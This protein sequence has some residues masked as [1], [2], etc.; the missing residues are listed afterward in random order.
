M[1]PCSAARM[2]RGFIWG[3]ILCF[4]LA[5]RVT[6][7]VDVDLQAKSWVFAKCGENVNLTCNATSS[8][9]WDKDMK[10]KKFI[11]MFGNKTMCH[12]EQNHTESEFQCE[13]IQDTFSHTITLTLNNVMP[14]DEGKYLCKFHST[15]G[16]KD[17]VSQLRIQDCLEN[18]G[19]SRN[20][21]YAECFFEGVYPS[22]VVHWYQGDTNL[23]TDV[24]TQET[25]D[26]RNHFNIRSS[27]KLK[28]E[29]LSEPYNC[30]LWIP[31]LGRYLATSEV[32]S[33]AALIKLQWVCVVVMV[34]V[35]FVM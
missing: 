22:G 28:K 23:T 4:C 26:K 15:E 6:G 29:S 17:S 21:T 20:T 24:S 8:Q 10:I 14:A 19:T 12:Y 9:P 13:S 2:H 27:I 1:R 16:A 25:K 33:S 3:L 30:S 7:K 32:N 31:S 11:W 5:A 18:S 35:S 34:L